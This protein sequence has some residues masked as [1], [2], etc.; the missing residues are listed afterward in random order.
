[1]CWKIEF[2]QLGPKISA[3]SLIIKIFF[4]PQKMTKSIK[5]KKWSKKKNLEVLEGVDSE[6]GIISFIPK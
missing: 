4:P 1:M 2:Y 3:P 6:S 5:E